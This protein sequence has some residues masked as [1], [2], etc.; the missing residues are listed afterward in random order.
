MPTVVKSGA[1]VFAKYL[2]PMTT[3]YR[4]VAMLAPTQQEDGH[5]VLENDSLQLVVHA[6]PPHIAA[7]FE[8]SDPPQVRE[9][10]SVK[11][12][13]PVADLAVARLAAAAHGGR[14]LPQENEWIWQGFR[15]CDGV[16]PEGNVFQLRAPAVADARAVMPTAPENP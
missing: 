12:V 4:E 6:I 5:A 1:V 14:L 15:V 3:F 11:L 7:T 8:I 13:F 9:E 2:Q 16:D 10:A